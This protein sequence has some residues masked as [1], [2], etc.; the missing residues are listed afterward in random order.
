[1]RVEALWHIS[2]RPAPGPRSAG[3]L[4]RNDNLMAVAFRPNSTA[5]T[6]GFILPLT[7][8]IIAAIGLVVVAVNAWV[9]QA[10]DNARVLRE[11][12]DMDLA[13]A[14]VQ[15]EL[16]FTLGS[17][18]MTYRGIEVGRLI[19]Q[20]DRTDATALMTADYRTDRYVRMDG[21]PYRLESKPDY[22]IRLYDGR[23]L[24]NL[25]AVNADYLRRM[26]G[27]FE[28]AEA[29]RNS[30][31]D[32]LED[33]T[34]RDDLTRIS[35]AE[36]QDYVRLGRRPPAN[37]WLM[38]PLEAQH[39]LGWDQIPALWKR[40][41]DAPLLSTCTVTGFNPNTAPREA[42]LS[43]FSGLLEEDIQAILARREE[44]P[45]RNIRE[46][47]A[48]ANTLIR[49]EPFYY[50]FAPG[51]CVIVELLHL[52]SGERVRFSLTV[53]TISAKTRPWRIDYAFPIPADPESPDRKSPPE[54]VFPAPDT[55]DAAQRAD[56]ESGGP[57]PPGALDREPG[58]D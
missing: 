3:R 19:E 18:P 46:F 31:V 8:W 15:N 2:T 30:L 23:G 7:L 33:Y 5:G 1:V 22:V 26:L 12:A 52:T 34:D 25:N 54:E 41:R 50:T 42:L 21:R 43:N 58:D 27:L 24:I 48:A 16:V 20:I 11:R 14:D 4:Q 37:A 45:F 53:D 28:I 47:A 9:S 40:D 57:G 32:A 38:T 35:G 13:V 17:R 39:V 6:R 29:E 36:A 44:R 55:L 56:G 49:D 10:V 51:A